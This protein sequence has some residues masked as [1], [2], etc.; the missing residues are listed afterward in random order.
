MALTLILSGSHERM[1]RSAE[2]TMT[3][4]LSLLI[5]AN[6]TLVVPELAGNPPLIAEI[7]LIVAFLMNRPEKGSVRRN[8]IPRPAIYKAG[9][10]A[11]VPQTTLFLLFSLP[12]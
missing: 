5:F 12:L 2:V 4:A 11:S 8:T 9:I 6:L 7:P 3:V 1:P 10:N